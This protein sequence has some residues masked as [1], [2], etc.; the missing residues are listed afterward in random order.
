MKNILVLYRGGGYDGCWWEWNYF[1]FDSTGKFY[2]LY[3]SGRNGIKTEEEAKKIL[4]SVPA[5]RGDTDDVYVYDLTDRDEIHDFQDN[6]AVPIVISVVKE[7]NSG[8]YGDYPPMWFVCDKCEE[9]VETG[10]M[11][12][13]HGCGGTAST[14]DTK[15]CNESYSSHT[16]SE[17]GE[18]DEHCID[19]DGLCDSCKETKVDDTLEVLETAG[20]VFLDYNRLTN[21]FVEV[22]PT[23]FS[24]ESGNKYWI[25]TMDCWE[26]Q[27][28]KYIIESDREYD[29]IESVH[30]HVDCMY[31]KVKTELLSD[32][33]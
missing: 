17:C 18:Y 7:L 27:T 29:A 12:N 4:A 10:E 31:H 30:R 23:D 3:T 1:S 5:E 33:S 2:N 6:C 22:S 19:N 9:R 16:C 15:I 20:Y 11:I 32:V 13:W 14:A 8:K 21:T 26:S 28:K 25:V 24:I